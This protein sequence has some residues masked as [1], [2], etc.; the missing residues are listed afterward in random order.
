[1]KIERSSEAWE[2]AKKL[3]LDDSKKDYGS[4]ILSKKLSVYSQEI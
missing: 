1:L 2:I 4:Q 3:I